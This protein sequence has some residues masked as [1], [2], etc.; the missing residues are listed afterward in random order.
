MFAEIVWERT[1]GGPPRPEGM[2]Q[3]FEVSATLYVHE[4][5][6]LPSGE[7][8]ITAPLIRSPLLWDEPFSSLASDMCRVLIW[9]P[10]LLVVH[11]TIH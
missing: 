8:V 3:G 7:R 6:A 10:D 1:L 2:W 9:V 4:V 11:E 5:V